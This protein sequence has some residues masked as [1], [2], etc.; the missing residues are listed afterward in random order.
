MFRI[1]VI[2]LIMY[3]VGMAHAQ[4]LRLRVCRNVYYL[5]K[6][7]PQFKRRLLKRP[8]NTDK[9]GERRARYLCTL[10]LELQT[11]IISPDRFM[12]RI[13]LEGG[14]LLLIMTI[15]HNALFNSLSN[16]TY[17]MN[18]LVLLSLCFVFR[19]DD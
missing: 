18:I 2:P 19:H 7:I 1:C 9:A 17:N 4:S 16:I 3:K 11:L 8:A 13:H 15:F 14:Y 5:D 12:G 6:S 10:T